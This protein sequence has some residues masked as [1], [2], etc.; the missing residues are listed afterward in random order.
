MVL[1]VTPSTP[2]YQIGRLIMIRA[3]VDMVDLKLP[4]LATF[5]TPPP[6]TVENLPA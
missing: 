4:G 2:R 3:M 1:Y 6:V 5:P